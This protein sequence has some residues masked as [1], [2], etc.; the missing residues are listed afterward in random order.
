MGLVNYGLFH[1]QYLECTFFF[2]KTRNILP[3]DGGGIILSPLK[4]IPLKCIFM[5]SICVEFNI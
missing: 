4:Y 2:S 1:F 3:S 5:K